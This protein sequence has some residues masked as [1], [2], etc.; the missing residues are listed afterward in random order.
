MKNII[1][2]FTFLFFIVL[3]WLSSS[4]PFF[5][6]TTIIAKLTHDFYDH[7]INGLI[8][9]M[10]S[11]QG[12]FSMFSIYMLCMWKMFGKTLF[13]SHFALLPFLFLIVYNYYQIASRFL[14]DKFIVLAMIL[15]MIEPCLLTQSIIMGY[16]IFMI[17]F[18]LGALNALLS[19]KRILFSILI[20][21]LC[22]CS[23]RGIMLSAG[24]FFLDIY[25][26]KKNHSHFISWKIIKTF[27]PSIVVLGLW[28]VYHHYKTGWY[29]INPLKEDTHQAFVLGIKPLKQLAYIFWKIMDMGRI[30]LWGVV[31]AGFFYFYKKNKPQFKDIFYITLIPLLMLIA[32]MIFIGNPIGHRYFIVIFLMLTILFCFVLQQMQSKKTVYITYIFSIIVL[33]TG[34]FWMY[35]VKYGNNWDSSL[36]VL[37]VFDLKKQV[38]DY[39]VKNNI[40]ATDV[41]TQFPFI[42][43]E[44]YMYLNDKD[45][46]YE[47]VWSGPI[48]KYPYFLYS[49]VI[50][51]DI[52]EQFEEARKN[53]ILI[54]EFKKGQVVFELYRNPKN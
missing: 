3:T 37:P 42:I 44:K 31:I 29:I 2:L 17:A 7:G 27:L 30:F 36:K 10:D 22:M 51:T 46:H 45:F 41:G 28:M 19:E 53:W 43:A 1:V 24:L 50:N 8:P 34:N 14:Q 9:P 11:D 12:G 49:N 23:I 52:A 4:F 5:W 54:K 20:V 39:I 13:V 18:F 47:N 6:D 40:S 35:P 48:D 32:G 26:L 33:I 16:D 21:L 15:L 25:F 38:D